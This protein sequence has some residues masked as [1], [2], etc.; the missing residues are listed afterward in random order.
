MAAFGGVTPEKRI[1]QLLRALSE[2]AERRPHLH[3]MLVG[4][5]VDHYDVAAEA[6]A[7]R[8]ADRVH[9]TG[10]VAD[11]ALPDYLA[12]SDF[13]ACMRWPTNRETSAS[14]LRCLGA[15]RA[16]IITELA[17]LADVP[18]LDPRGWQVKDVVPTPRQPVA[19]SID[20]LDEDHSLPLALERLAADAALRGSLG[21]AARAWWSAHHRLQPMADAYMELF[22]RARALAAP[23]VTLPAHLV[24]DGSRLVETLLDDM[25]LPLSFDQAMT[26]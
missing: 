16:T 4:G 1:P 17:H 13:C 21:R 18:T 19:V 15:A 5:A 9:V 7:W 8:V 24:D 14:W 20:L 10:Y 11:E 22:E 2:V 26:S 23:Q 6:R 25:G 12:A 3:L